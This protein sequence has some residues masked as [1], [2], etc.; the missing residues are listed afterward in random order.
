MALDAHPSFANAHDLAAQI[1]R[2]KRHFDAAREHH[3]KALKLQPL[4]G[5]FHV[6][7]ASF[8]LSVGD[9][10]EAYQE[11]LKG[12]ELDPKIP[13]FALGNIVKAMGH[14]DLAA[15]YYAKARTFAPNASEAFASE[16]MA[17]LQMGDFERGWTL[18]EK[19][20]D[21]NQTLGPLPFWN[22]Q[23]NLHL[24]VYDDQGIGDTLQ[25]LRFI[26]PLSALCARL[27]WRVP[28]SLFRLCQDNF[29]FVR[30]VCETEPS[31]VFDARCR[32]SSLGAFFVPTLSDVDGGPYLKENSALKNVFAPHLT[33]VRLPRIGV[34]WAGNPAF[35]YDGQR[36]ISFEQFEPLL[37]ALGC[38]GVSLQKGQEEDS[39]KLETLAVLNIA[40][41]L[42]D[43][44]DT[45]AVIASLDLVVTV[46]TAVAHLA[47][48]LGKPVFILLPFDSDWRW[49]IGRDDTPWY[50]KTRVF[51]QKVPGD[52]SDVLD[53]VAAV[54]T[55]FVAGDTSVLGPT[56]VTEQCLRKNPHALPLAASQHS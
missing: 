30:V 25:F 47:G 2:D 27:T 20:P 32:L 45:A 23:K 14:P 41:E 1:F 43:F 6:N 36:S 13:P 50:R 4:K 12:T 55:R 34:V 31:D 51:R 49:L 11:A 48:A 7:Y 53:S 18:W 21:L 42:E 29:P 19:R 9:L 38:H 16:A 56:F 26:R 37:S 8:L 39:K 46:D 52:W 33:P 17:H 40:R 28:A 22:G 44:A 54:L 15:E 24:L 10:E 3:L 5:Y 35:R